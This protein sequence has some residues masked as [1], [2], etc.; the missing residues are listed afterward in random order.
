MLFLATSASAPMPKPTA[1]PGGNTRRQNNSTVIHVDSWNTQT[2]VAAHTDHQQ[3]EVCSQNA[4]LVDRSLYRLLNTLKA[5]LILQAGQHETQHVQISTLSSSAVCSDR[6]ATA[7]INNT[8]HME[9]IVQQIILRTENLLLKL[10]DY[11]CRS[12]KEKPARVVDC[13][14]HASPSS[15]CTLH[16]T[17]LHNQLVSGV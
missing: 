9:N 15:A 7:D 16:N 10:E 17:A 8:V 2:A 13:S 4:L 12:L 11:F 14:G 5:P 1:R 6:P 3:T